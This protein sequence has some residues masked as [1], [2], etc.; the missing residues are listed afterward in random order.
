MATDPKT[1]LSPND[2]PDAEVS[3]APPDVEVL[4]KA[5]RR[6]FSAEY[7]LDIVRKADACKEAGQIGALLRREGL[8][9]S[10]LVLWR[11]QRDAG[12]LGA[13][14]QQKRGPKAKVVDPEVTALTKENARLQRK[15]TQAEAIIEVQKKIA[16]ILGI[17]PKPQADDESD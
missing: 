6:R 13:M 15:L 3:R 9:S 17:H 11:R 7:R 12:A 4:E 8:Y 1:R 14:R 16:E 5:K 10:Q 2:V